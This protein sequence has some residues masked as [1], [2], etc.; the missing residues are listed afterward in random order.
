[1]NELELSGEDKQGKG[2]RARRERRGGTWEEEVNRAGRDGIGSELNYGMETRVKLGGC[3]PLWSS[4]GCGIGKHESGMGEFF[5]LRA[6]RRSHSKPFFCLSSTPHLLH[7]PTSTPRQRMKTDYHGGTNE[8]CSSWLFLRLTKLSPASHPL[9]L[10][11][12]MEEGT[13]LH[14][15]STRAI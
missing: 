13:P 10:S 1:M 2:C 3:P 8:D 14:L 15:S 12:H 11:N 7:L 4:P 6:V 9:F 5:R